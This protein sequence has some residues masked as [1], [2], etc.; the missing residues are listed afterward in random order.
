LLLFSK[1]LIQTNLVL[2]DKEF[3]N[4]LISNII[5]SSYTKSL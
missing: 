4:K 2:N 5:I 1:A 3:I